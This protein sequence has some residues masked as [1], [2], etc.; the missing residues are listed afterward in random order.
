MHALNKRHILIAQTLPPQG[1]GELMPACSGLDSIEGQKKSRTGEI[2]YAAVVREYG[3]WFGWGT[4]GFDSPS[5]E[6][7]IHPARAGK[8]ANRSRMYASMELFQSTPP[9]RGNTERQQRC[10][11]VELISIHPARAGEYSKHQ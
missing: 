2:S 10:R 1:L 6:G 4:L 3:V 7:V 11:Q 9:K 8:C 5:C